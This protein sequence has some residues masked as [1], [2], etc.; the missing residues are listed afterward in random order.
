MKFNVL[1]WAAVCFYYRS[2]GDKRYR[3]MMSDQD[4]LKRIRNVP[5][6]LSLKEF[7]EKVVLGLVN[8]EHYDLLMHHRLAETILQKIIDLVM[9]MPIITETSLVTCDV[10]APETAAVIE[11]TFSIL[12]VNGLWITGISKIAHILNDRLFPILSPD[13]VKHFNITDNGASLRR[14]LCNVQED[15]REA[16]TDFNACGFQGS[17]G[18]FL[19]EK[20]GYTKEGYEKS[21]VKLADEYYWLR[22]GDCLPIPPIWAPAVILH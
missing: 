11:R 9:E 8:M 18:R 17:P 16:T 10:N 14:W 3:A 6:E 12:K 1:A 13:L 20:L 7:E 19:S 15:I 21:L 2:A 5:S 4:F 22:Y